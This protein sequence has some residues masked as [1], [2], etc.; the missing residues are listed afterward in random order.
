MPTAQER[1]MIKKNYDRAL[2]DSNTALKLNPNNAIAYYA[3]GNTYNYGKSDYDRAIADY[4]QAIRIN[5]SYAVA[6][7]NRGLSYQ[8]KGDTVRANADF[9]KARELGY[10]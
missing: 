4:T 6:Y 1:T 8:A 7:N 10:K 3:R 5:P 2:A 9:A